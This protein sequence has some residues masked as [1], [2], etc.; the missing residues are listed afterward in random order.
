MT[1]NIVPRDAKRDNVDRP[2]ESPSSTLNS[3]NG[4][5]E[6]R[7]IA[8]SDVSPPPNGGLQAWLQVLGSFFFFSILGR[9][10][11]ILRCEALARAICR[12]FD[13]NP[14]LCVTGA[15]STLSVSFRHIMKAIS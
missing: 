9:L 5:G 10:S 4:T 13:V 6:K 12:T 7:V 14:H 2:A 8:A 11:L 15:L 3:A 1:G